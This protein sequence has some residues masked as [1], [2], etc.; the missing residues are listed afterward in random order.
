MRKK[1]EYKPAGVKVRIAASFWFPGVT[2]CIEAHE[3]ICRLLKIH[4]QEGDWFVQLGST[5]QSYRVIE[6]AK[7][8]KL[9]LPKRPEVEPA[10]ICP[11]ID[12]SPEEI[13]RE[14][15]A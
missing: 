7:A 11:Q 9:G 1:R 14:V 12:Q 15:G 4:P 8:V 3:M 2:T 5:E 10:P 13:A 6:E